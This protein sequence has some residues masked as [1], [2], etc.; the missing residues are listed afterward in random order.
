VREVGSDNDGWAEPMR[1]AIPVSAFSSHIADPPPPIGDLI[2]EIFWAAA[3]GRLVREL[4]HVPVQN[5]VAIY[6]GPE[7]EAG[8][9]W[10]IRIRRAAMPGALFR[11]GPLRRLP[12]PPSPVV[13]T[14]EVSFLIGGGSFSLTAP[15][16][17]G[18]P[19]I[20]AQQLQDL[21]A[22][23]EFIAVQLAADRDGNYV[24][25]VRAR[26]RIGF[27]RLRF[28]Y[29]RAW[30]LVGN[31]DPG[32]PAR[33]VLAVPGGTAD[34]SRAYALPYVGVLDWLVK[35]AVERQLEAAVRWIAGLE[36]DIADAGFS[37]ETVSVS[38]VRV[39]GFAS[40]AEASASV[41]L[42]AGA[43]TRVVL[44]PTPGVRS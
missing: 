15:G 41:T 10:A 22:P 9:Y 7:L 33:P 36:L 13:P 24:V 8:V 5:G 14:G 1:Q 17:E 16:S 44:P 25:T 42:G 38:E 28:S 34:I 20:V 35:D 12:G 39:F 31:V 21:P 32:R 18:Q 6:D 3:D 29:R 30:Q 23:L 37:A 26:L 40:P 11:S 43:I 19:E 27:L 4:S 2:A